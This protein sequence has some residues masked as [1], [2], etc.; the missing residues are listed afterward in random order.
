M[1]R[2]PSLGVVRA[3]TNASLALGV[4]RASTY[5]PLAQGRN[6]VYYTSDPTDAHTVLFVMGTQ[7]NVSR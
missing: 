1:S 3:S 2:F 4:V 6:W 7:N 5:A